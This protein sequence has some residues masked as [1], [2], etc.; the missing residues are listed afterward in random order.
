MKGKTIISLLLLVGMLAML[1]FAGG[2]LVPEGEEGEGG[3][4]NWQMIAIIGAIFVIFY[5]LMIRPQQKKQKQQQQMTQELKV[6]DRVITI[7][8]IFGQIEKIDEESVVLKVESGA[9]IR[10]SRN[11]IA[12]TQQK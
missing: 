9:T 8:G 7:G 6:G 2:C 11:S 4:F 3:G 1:A 10:M 5:F 12:G